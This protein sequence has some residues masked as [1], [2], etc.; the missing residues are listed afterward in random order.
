MAGKARKTLEKR[1]VPREHFIQLRDIIRRAT[2]DDHLLDEFL[3]DLLTPAEYAELA[4]R[5]QIVR[6]LAMG[7]TQREIT[8]KLHISMET[9]SRGAR[10][11]LDKRGGFR[12]LLDHKM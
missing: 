5:W 9:V 6:L 7:M 12:K 2:K 10:E 4:T 8:R 1:D 3:T 11:L